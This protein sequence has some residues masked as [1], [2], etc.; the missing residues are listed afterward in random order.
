MLEDMGLDFPKIGVLYFG[1]HYN[2]DPSIK[3]TT[4][5]PPIF[6]TPPQYRGTLP[7]SVRLKAVQRVPQLPPTK[8]FVGCD[9]DS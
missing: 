8:P 7:S 5:G 4:L 6:G 9:S 1:V 3:G 2:K